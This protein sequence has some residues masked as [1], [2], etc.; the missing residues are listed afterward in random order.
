MGKD[1]RHGNKNRDK[2]RKFNKDEHRKQ[3]HEKA[4]LRSVDVDQLLD[5]E[6]EAGNTFFSTDIDKKEENRSLFPIGCENEKDFL[7]EIGDEKQL[8]DDDWQQT[9]NGFSRDD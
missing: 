3:K 6:D 4:A 7:R 8:A 9:A 2:V 5:V 1:W